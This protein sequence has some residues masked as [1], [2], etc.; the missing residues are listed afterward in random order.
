MRTAKTD[1]TGQM[2]SL[3][4]VFAWCTDNFVCFVMQWLICIFFFTRFV[5]YLEP[6]LLLGKD[7]KRVKFSKY[8]L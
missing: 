7:G 4:R 2:P 8:A 5:S 3:L 1:Q 6:C